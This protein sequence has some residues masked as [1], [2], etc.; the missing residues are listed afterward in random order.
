MPLRFLLIALMLCTSLSTFMSTTFATPANEPMEIRYIDRGAADFLNA[1]KYEL[2]KR[3]LDLTTPEFGDYQIIPYRDDPGAKR[4]A[5]LVNDGHLLNITWASPGTVRDNTNTLPIPVDL[6]K[7][8]QGN[9]VC[10]IDKKRQVFF[11]GINNLKSLKDIRIGQGANW[12]DADIY[13]SNNLDVIKGPNIEGLINM[14]A[15]GRFDCLALGI[16]EADDILKKYLPQYPW[17]ALEKNLLIH[18]DFPIYLYISA[19]H[20]RLAERLQKGIQ[21][22]KNNGEFDAIFS[23]HYDKKINPLNLSQRKSFCLISPY[24]PSE[25]QCTP[26]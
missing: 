5:A 23:H 2:I 11:D 13:T 17:L 15:M 9:R 8:T 22:L 16:N 21:A 19:H 12:E 18:Y 7:G 1:P 4:L 26:K 20:P 24:L 10:L 14:L 6:L 3:A 25:S